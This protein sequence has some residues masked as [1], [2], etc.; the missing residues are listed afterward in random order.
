[1]QLHNR[2]VL[3]VL[4]ILDELFNW[5]CWNKGSPKNILKKRRQKV[6][7]KVF[8]NERISVSNVYFSYSSMMLAICLKMDSNKV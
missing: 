8:S 2:G 4:F 7:W 1:M 3:S 5:L 6:I